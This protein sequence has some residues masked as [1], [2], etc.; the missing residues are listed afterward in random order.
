MLIF[1]DILY[2]YMQYHM[3]VSLGI[4]Y[5]GVSGYIIC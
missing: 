3:F 4:S 5:V 1:L 2:K